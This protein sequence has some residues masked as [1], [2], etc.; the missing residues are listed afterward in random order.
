MKPGVVKRKGVKYGPEMSGNLGTEF[1]PERKKL[2]LENL[3]ASGLKTEACRVIGVSIWT[4]NEHLKNDADFKQGFEDAM[5]TYR[6]SLV[7]EIH[8]RGVDGVVEP[9]FYKGARVDKGALLR[10]SDTLLLALA[11]R[12]IP[13]FREKTE[14]TNVNLDTGLADLEKLSPEQREALKRLLDTPANDPGSGMP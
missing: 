7:K 2:W 10:F 13:E 5:Y 12:H 6:E 9:V 1:S 8:R 4:V 14:S 11:R 3:A